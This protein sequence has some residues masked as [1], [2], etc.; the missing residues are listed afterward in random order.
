VAKLEK[1]RAIRMI[2]PAGMAD[3]SIIPGGEW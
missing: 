1:L 2:V 3:E